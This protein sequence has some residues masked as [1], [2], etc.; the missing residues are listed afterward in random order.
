MSNRE[1]MVFPLGGK[2]ASVN[3]QTVGSTRQIWGHSPGR[4][5]DFFAFGDFHGVLMPG[6]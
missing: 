1:L 6:I 4:P 2:V 3:V 5:E